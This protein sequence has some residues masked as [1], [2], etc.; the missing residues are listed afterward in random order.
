MLFVGLAL[1]SARHGGQVALTFDACQLAATLVMTRRSSR[2]FVVT[3]LLL[4]SF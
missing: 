4:R 3:V 2:F 1:I